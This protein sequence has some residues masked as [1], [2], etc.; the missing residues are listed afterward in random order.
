MDRTDSL[1]VLVQDLE[2]IQ[3]ALA[4]AEDLSTALDIT[5]GIRDL[6]VQH[7]PSKLTRR[8]AHASRRVR[9]ILA[10]ATDE[11]TD[12]EPT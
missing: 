11:V 4:H 12:D 1:P 7:R 9:G 2:M 5:H 10:A 3:S 8:L 6:Q